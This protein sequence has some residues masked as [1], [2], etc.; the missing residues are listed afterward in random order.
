MQSRDVEGRL[1]NDFNHDH[2]DKQYSSEKISAD[3]NAKT[4]ISKSYYTHKM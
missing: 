1:R 2:F 3:K 4:K